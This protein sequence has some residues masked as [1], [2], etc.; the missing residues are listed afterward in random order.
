MLNIKVLDR[1]LCLLP[2]YAPNV[3]SE[4]QA[5]VDEVNYALLRVSPTESTVLMGEFNAHVGTD[6][7]TWK[8]VIRKHGVTGLNENARCLLEL[9]C[10]NGFR[11]MNTCY[12][13]HSNSRVANE[14]I[15]VLFEFCNSSCKINTRLAK[16]QKNNEKCNNNPNPIHKVMRY[17]V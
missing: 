9:C 17:E 14:F 8:G 10:S 6:T 13:Q 16:A 7:D 5:F 15:G 4:I 2:V 12:G 1:S 11:I 3:T